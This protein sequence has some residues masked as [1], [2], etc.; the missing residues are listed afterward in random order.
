MRDNVRLGDGLIDEVK[1]EINAGL[2]RVLK[3]M[4]DKGFGWIEKNMDNPEELRRLIKNPEM[5]Q[6]FIAL[7]S[8]QLMEEGLIPTGYNGLPNNLLASNLHQ[9]GYLSGLYVGYVM[10]MMALADNDAPEELIVTIRDNMR[11]NLMGCH[12]NNREQFVTR[13]K[14]DEKYSW[15]EE[16]EKVEG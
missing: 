7:W 9:D 2:S 1:V 13:Y 14:N 10:A 3:R 6:E 5:E 16:T 8:E 15:I 4:I 11:S 12:Y